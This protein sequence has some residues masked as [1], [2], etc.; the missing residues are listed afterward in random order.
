M[1][2]G[3]APGSW[4]QYAVT[5]VSGKKRIIACDILPIEPIIGVDF[6]QGDFCDPLVF[7]ALIEL[8]GE[9]KV[10]VVLSDMA[11]NMSGNSAIDAPK[12]LYLA[13]LA[14]EMCR[15]TLV[16]GGSFLVKT[17]QGEGFNE[18]FREVC[19]LFTKV[20]IR[21][22]DASRARSREVYIVAMGYKP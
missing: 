13:E 17:F 15:H 16:P 11:P 9:Q 21:K 7:Q 18:Y 4:S 1:D 14:L 10:Q 8:I 19:S 6:L 2:L 12:S 5:Q 22:P 3:A 20:K